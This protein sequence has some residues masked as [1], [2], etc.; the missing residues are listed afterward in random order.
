MKYIQ[1]L[2]LASLLVSFGAALVKFRYTHRTILTRA[3]MVFLLLATSFWHV[4]KAG[5]KVSNQTGHVF[6]FRTSHMLKRVNFK[7]KDLH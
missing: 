2:Y 1:Y 7:A 4:Q 3:I 5:K 6:P